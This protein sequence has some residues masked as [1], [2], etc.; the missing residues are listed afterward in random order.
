MTQENDGAGAAQRSVTVARSFAAPRELVFRAWS[1]AEH[2]R[3]WFCPAGFTV[4]AAEVDFRP[5]G[6]FAVC[7]RAPDGNEFWSRGAFGEIAPPER[8]T[9]HGG[10]EVG[11]TVR[12][13]AHTTVTFETERMGTRVLVH[14]T[15][16]IFDTSFHAAI[17]GAPEGWRTTLDNLA[18][19]VGR[20][21]TE[22]G[23][24]VVHGSFTLSR[25]YDAAPALV[26][27]AFTDPAAKAR[28]FGGGEGVEVLDRAMDVRPGGT[29]R[30]KVRWTTGMVS[31]FE[32][33]YCDVVPDARLIYLYEMRLDARK[34][35]ASLATVELRP[36]GAGTHLTITEHGAFLDGFEDAG[37]REHGTRWLLDRLAVSLD[38]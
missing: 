26:F 34:I 31:C 32:A 30:M 19:E 1:S 25:R 29:E 22:Q 28:W 33:T 13:T 2:V 10:A 18:D 8:L 20:L 36:E 23:R 38:G 3:R 4:P 5:G 9:F 27:R 17:D 6:V 16:E 37:M 21:C 7:M 14:Q 15:Y 24:S 35:S 12:F 11:G